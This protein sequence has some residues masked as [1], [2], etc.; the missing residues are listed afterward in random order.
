[1]SSTFFPRAAVALALLAAAGCTVKDSTPPP[2][3]GPSGLAL[4]LTLN[5][6]PDS[7]SQDGGSQSSIRVTAIGPDGR[8]RAALPLRIDMMV[9][10]TPQDYG[11]LSART[12]VT[13]SDGVA[14]VIYTAPASPSNGV[15]GTCSGLVGNCVSIV[16]TATSTDFSGANPEQVLIRLVPTGIILPPADTPAEVA[17]V[18]S[19]S[20]QTN[21]AV[22]FDASG[23]CGGPLVAGSCPLTASAIS[24]YA[25]TFGDGSTGTG[26]TPSHTYSTANTYTVGLTVTNARGVSAS[27]TVPVPV[28][29]SAAPTAQ[30]VF[31]PQAPSVGQSVIFNADGARAASGR[32]ITQYS[33]IFGDGTSGSGSVTSH[34]FATAGSYAVTLSVLDDAGQKTTSSVTV[35][36]SAATGGA[37]NATAAV[38][39]TSPSTPVVNQVV[40]FNG[41]GS[42]ASTGHTLTRYAWDFGDGT[43]TVGV[44]SSTNHTY[45]TAGTYTAALVVTDDASVTARTTGSVT[46]S[47]AGAVA[48]TARF[49]FSPTA[50][51]GV[52][53]TLFFNAAQSTAG[54]GH[55]LSTY[56]WDFGDGSIGAGS[57]PTHAYTRAGTFV[58]TLVVTDEAGQTGTTST[59]VTV[60]ASSSQIV[61]AFGFSPIGPASGSP[62]HFDATPSIGQG[63][64]TYDWNW[65]DGTAPTPNGGML[66]NHT[67]A[68]AGTYVVRLT[69]TDST[70]AT[71]TTTVNVPV[72]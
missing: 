55:T 58:V 72:S 53:Q 54:T 62:V 15:Y 70:G 3:T 65:G 21:T 71:A 33:W 23:S 50:T 24:S 38:F 9:N 25:W 31:S 67:F 48:P 35:A 10:G 39:V 51:P 32:T 52:N 59:P 29:A 14:T 2:L 60:A 34:A 41:S 18:T 40:F 68:A 5:A 8:G 7:I 46:V 16:A 44:A 1:M 56:A 17:R 13:N 27:T 57:A 6:V 28:A 26:Q 37:G 66:L 36:V 11:T 61:A 4:T 69:V 22:L 19:G 12:L 20:A 63:A 43:T 45:T 30:F 64:L 49:T 47:A 42:S